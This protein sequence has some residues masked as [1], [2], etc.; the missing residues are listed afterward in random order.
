MVNKTVY[1]ALE[2]ALLSSPKAYLKFGKKGDVIIVPISVVNNLYNFSGI[3]KVFASDVC[4]YLSRIKLDEEYEQSDGTF[5]RVMN[6]DSVID[7][8]FKV[9][10]NILSE[11][12]QK[13]LALCKKLSEIYENCDVVLL[14]QNP[15]LLLQASGMGIK[16]QTVSDMI[17]PRPKD[18]YSGISDLFVSSDLFD[19]FIL[20]KKIKSPQ[21]FHE[22]EFIV[23]HNSDS[24]AGGTKI[25][26]Y[27]NGTLDSLHFQL[28]RNYTP[29]NLEQT[30]LVESLYAPPSIAPL[31]IV[32]G[33]AGTGKSFSAVSAAMNQLQN[34]KE[35]ETNYNKIIISTPAITDIG[36]SLGYL[37]GDLVQKS[38]PYFGGIFDAL[39][40]V[41]GEKNNYFNGGN[42]YRKKD[43]Y[44]YKSKILN[45]ME[46]G[47]IELM[48][49]GFL[50]GHS[51]EN[52][53]VIVDEAQNIDPN[54]FINII[55]RMSH[56]SKL[57]ILGDPYQV[58]ASGL[59]RNINGIIYMMETWKDERLAWQVQMNSH[60]AVRSELCQRAIDIMS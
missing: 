31:V 59:S 8:D 16:T 36:E 7:A 23:L 56:D 29:K 44:N 55:T 39:S 43:N 6:P 35:Y 19:E 54:F 47:L 57:V 11:N 5:I 60:M 49:L 40:K 2:G 21:K 32:S 12:K 22:N 48:P 58:K 30:V 20:N 1:V 37:P 15:A 41:I 24:P 13:S 4:D 10:G 18:R 17:F 33:A 45:F 26:R 34:N 25:A 53:F 51:F 38:S 27:S 28:A 46:F 9:Q 3:K 42:F 14:S 52:S 50:A